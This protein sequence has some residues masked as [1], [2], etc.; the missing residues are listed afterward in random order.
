MWRAARGGESGAINWRD[1]ATLGREARA[2]HWAWWRW[3]T[4]RQM[5]GGGRI[6]SRPD[7]A[8]INDDKLRRGNNCFVNGTSSNRECTTRSRLTLNATPP[9]ELCR[10]T[11]PGRPATAL[12]RLFSK[13]ED[14]A[15]HETMSFHFQE[16][17][18]ATLE[19]ATP[20]WKHLQWPCPIAVT[21]GAQCSTQPFSLI[22]DRPS[23]LARI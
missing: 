7:E 16:L 14:C 4:A 2:S 5:G 18:E 3:C 17:A 22:R 15:L 12:P 21:A 6:R 13:G 19:R 10:P 20:T 23:T 9:Q 11:L 1:V 8:R